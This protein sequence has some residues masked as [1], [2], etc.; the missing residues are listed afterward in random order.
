MIGTTLDGRY[1]ILSLIGEGSMS[2][3]YKASHS[4]MQR[5]VAI[6]MLKSHLSSDPAMLMRFQ[7]ES[8]AVGVLSHANIVSIYDC[9]ITSD[10][11]PY[12]VMDLIEG[13]SLASRL[14]RQGKLPTEEAIE[15]TSAVASGLAH[16]HGHG[17]IHR[18]VKPS[19]ILLP[20]KQSTG[21]TIK[22]ID[23]GIAKL[24]SLDDAAVQKLTQSGQLFGSPIYASPEQCMGRELDCRSDIY[25]LGCVLYE[26]LS[27]NKPFDG[28]TPVEIASKHLTDKPP[29]LEESEGE[30]K[31]LNGIV[32]KCIEKDKTRRF[33]SVSEFKD[34]LRPFKGG[35]DIASTR[36][37]KNRSFAS[38]PY[39]PATL[40]LAGLLSLVSFLVNP[41]C[42]ILMKD[43]KLHFEEGFLYPLGSPEV[44][45]RKIANAEYCLNNGQ[46]AD[47]AERFRQILLGLG[48]RADTS[49]TDDA[50]L[51]ASLTYK[52]SLCLTYLGH[53]SE[54]KPLAD[55]ASE[56]VYKLIP[57]QPSG[58]K[59]E[60][61]L[62]QA[63]TA[64]RALSGEGSDRLLQYQL[65]LA[66]IYLNEKRLADA[67]EIWEKVV[68]PA[69]KSGRA[70]AV[71]KFLEDTGRSLS[72]NGNY[73]ASI[74]AHEALIKSW[75]EAGDLRNGA[76]VNDL[77]YF[78]CALAGNKQYD[79]AEQ[80]IRQE[81]PQLEEVPYSKVSY[82][83]QLAKILIQRGQEKEGWGIL[84]KA[85]TLALSLR[86]QGKSQ[87][88]VI[89]C[90]NQLAGQYMEL[91]NYKL[92][93]TVQKL[94]VD[95][96]DNSDYPVQLDR[97]T[98][99]MRYEDILEH[100][101]LDKDAR[102]VR[103]EIEA[104]KLL[105]SGKH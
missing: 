68:T 53:R 34:A 25:S 26:M 16:A 18:D 43:L 40:L 104:L 63:I 38:F 69:L 2:H 64:E 75:Q 13:E 41:Q 83:T 99:L 59:M 103:T 37:A 12:L 10:G 81:L 60:A 100:L 80:I 95:I 96:A 90:M 44:V 32:F 67:G 94:A 88:V 31:Q 8:K 70:P 22:L 54:A 48:I 20:A 89:G 19:N 98:V 50:L 57:V 15:I 6:K 7:Q 87:P 73:K 14:T 24:L 23:F 82:M 17:I 56:L 27:G 30:L 29:P 62:L 55:Q 42:R 85:R 74:L 35:A 3:V 65:A 47:A 11:Q 66:N 45:A 71:R 21:R 61:V 72:A 9:G 77:F 33:Q 28:S 1:E 105:L 76:Y 101:G 78:S 86:D 39:L 92:A 52:Q 79:R 36:V 49:N 97:L 93:E 84:E 5:L 58:A 102:K 46:F 4:L 51:L 91:G